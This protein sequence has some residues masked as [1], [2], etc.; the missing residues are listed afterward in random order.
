MRGEDFVRIAEV[1]HSRYARARLVQAYLDSIDSRW[2]MFLPRYSSETAMKVK[3]ADLMMMIVNVIRHK[4]TGS[5]MTARLRCTH[6]E[7]RMQ[8]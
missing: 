4:R 2:N 7:G 1:P 5:L 6:G 8:R 3:L